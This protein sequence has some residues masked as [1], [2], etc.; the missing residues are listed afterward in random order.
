MSVPPAPWPSKVTFIVVAGVLH[1][2]EDMGYDIGLASLAAESRGRQ[3]Q[4]SFLTLPAT[5]GRIRQPN[6]PH[7]RGATPHGSN[8]HCPQY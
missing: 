5:A 6:R 8:V 3:P 4:P 2:R 1:Y 7:E